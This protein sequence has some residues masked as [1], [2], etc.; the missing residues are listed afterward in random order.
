MWQKTKME[1]IRYSP[2]TV[3][4]NIKAAKWCCG[5]M[6][7]RSAKDKKAATSRN[8]SRRFQEVC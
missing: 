2:Y 1:R 5:K 6:E 4:V 8:K 3:H 7:Q